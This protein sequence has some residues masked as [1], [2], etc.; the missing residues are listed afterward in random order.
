MHFNSPNDAPALRVRHL[1]ATTTSISIG[2]L[3]RPPCPLGGSPHGV[4]ASA[5]HFLFG[6]PAFLRLA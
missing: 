1:T 5:L 4:A 2:R 6:S 3:P